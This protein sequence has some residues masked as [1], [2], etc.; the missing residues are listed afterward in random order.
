MALSKRQGQFGEYWGND[1]NS[2]NA[3]TTE[4]MKVNAYY[5]YSALLD[6]GWSKN[7]ICA[8]LGNMQSESSINPGRWQSD[9]VGGDSSGH[10]YSLVQWTPY[11]KYTNWC[12]SNGYSDPSEM[13]TA[14]ARIIY[15]VE[16]KI[17]WIATSVYDMTFEDFTKSP[18][19]PSILAKAFMLCYERPADQS[20]TKQ[21]QRGEQANY[22]YE[23]LTGMTPSNPDTENK[24]KKKRYKFILF[25][26]R[27]RASHG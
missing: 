23:Y 26:R 27:R 24:K 11:T 8:L 9:R 14:L 25:D 7:A 22:W 12:S 19:S 1:Y 20:V 4:Q 10:G 2:S 17:Q 16:N 3:L 21:N 6:K 13:D 18:N 5:I 15:E